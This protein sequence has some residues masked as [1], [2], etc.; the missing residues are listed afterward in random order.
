MIG[1]AFPP[2]ITLGICV[3][4][5]KDIYICLGTLQR[6]C[7]WNSGEAASILNTDGDYGQYPGCTP[8][9]VNYTGSFSAID[10]LNPRGRIH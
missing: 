2:V 7:Y 10:P 3:L 9:Q 1:V 4:I 5:P 6:F 8:Y